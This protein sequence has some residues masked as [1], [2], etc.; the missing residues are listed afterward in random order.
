MPIMGVLLLLLVLVLSATGFGAAA[1]A[2]LS[3]VCPFDALFG[4]D[5][6]V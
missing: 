2:V 4:L 5:R 1:V 3:S 6:S